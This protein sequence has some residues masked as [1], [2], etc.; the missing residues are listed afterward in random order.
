[1]ARTI[2][3]ARLVKPGRV[4]QGHAPQNPYALWLSGPPCKRCAPAGRFRRAMSCLDEALRVAASD[5]RATDFYDGSLSDFF[6][7][8]SSCL[9]AFVRSSTHEQKS[10]SKSLHRAPNFSSRCACTRDCYLHDPPRGIVAPNTRLS[11]P[12]SEIRAVTF[13]PRQ[14]KEFSGHRSH[15]AHM[16]A[17]PLCSL[18]LMLLIVA[19]R[20]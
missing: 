19:I 10:A 4:S 1:M 11:L 13:A 8:P 2:S 3:L 20:H 14:R 9:A 18:L 6:I 15:R 7:A 16:P 12:L 17:N 5:V